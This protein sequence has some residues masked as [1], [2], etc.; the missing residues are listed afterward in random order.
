MTYEKKGFIFSLIILLAIIIIPEII[1]F[2]LIHIM[3]LKIILLIII[4][5]LITGI[6]LFYTSKLP[7]KPEHILYDSILLYIQKLISIHG[8][9]GFLNMIF[10]KGF[11]FID[12]SEALK[13]YFGEM[14]ISLNK[15]E[16][17]QALQFCGLSY[18]CFEHF[19]WHKEKN[20]SQIYFKQP[21]IIKIQ[22][23]S[24][25][26]LYLKMKIIDPVYIV[27]SDMNLDILY[28]A[29]A[30]PDLMKFISINMISQRM[31]QL[32]PDKQKI[33]DIMMINH[34]F[35]NLLAG[36]N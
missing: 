15:I 34:I 7:A 14:L 36:D 33:I 26:S 1:I 3:I 29:S 9:E 18:Y 8:N 10:N 5:I 4:P 24:H 21:L 12:A 19:I 6:I 13:G 31:M 22:K 23:L 17:A 25:D 30:Q 11:Q 2:I 20:F 32:I 28:T 35:I 16:M 27:S